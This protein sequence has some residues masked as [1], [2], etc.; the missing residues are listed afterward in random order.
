MISGIYSGDSGMTHTCTSA[1]GNKM[2]DES[3]VT[4]GDARKAYGLLSSYEG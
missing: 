4:S 3:H 1:R 2:K